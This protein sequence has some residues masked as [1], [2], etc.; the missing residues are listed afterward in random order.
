MF[1]S[2]HNELNNETFLCL[3]RELRE[4]KMSTKVTNQGLLES[5]VDAIYTVELTRTKYHSW[6]KALSPKMEC[7]STEHLSLERWV[8]ETSIVWNEN[9]LETHTKIADSHML[10]ILDIEDK[11]SQ[12]NKATGL[13]MSFF[14]LYFFSISCVSRSCMR[15]ITFFPLKL[16]AADS[17]PLSVAGVED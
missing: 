1:T 17:F 9:R 11:T 6:K 3:D 10:Q 13:H 14:E 5:R 16:H 15:E 2:M 12:F 4:W 8:V 7:S